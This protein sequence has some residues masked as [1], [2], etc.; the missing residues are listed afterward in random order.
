MP[1]SLLKAVWTWRWSAG[2]FCCRSGVSRAQHS[3]EGGEERRRGGGEPAWQCVWREKFLCWQIPPRLGQNAGIEMK[4]IPEF[5]TPVSQKQFC[6][7]LQSTKLSPGF[8][9]PDTG[10]NSSLWKQNEMKLSV[11]S[12]HFVLFGRKKEKFVSRRQRGRRAWEREIATSAALPR[13]RG[14]KAV[15]VGE[16]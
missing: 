6:F 3:Q 8:P 10:N 16:K 13:D 1:F 14:R 11:I 4:R 5:F 7:L 9:R 2:T 12:V 15:K